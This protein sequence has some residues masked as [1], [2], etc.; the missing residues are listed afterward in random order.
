[1]YFCSLFKKK[2]P[3]VKRP[4][5]FLS[6]CCCMITFYSCSPPIS[7]DQMAQI[8]VEIYSLD[9]N[10]L[11]YPDLFTIGDTTMVYAALLKNN[12]Y[13]VKDFNRSIARHL[14]KPDKMKK[15]LTPYRDELMK[16]KNALQNELDEA[17]KELEVMEI[18]YPRKPIRDITYPLLSPNL[19][20][21]TMQSID[22]LKLLWASF[23]ERDTTHTHIFSMDVDP[24]VVADSLTTTHRILKDDK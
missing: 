2:L 21:V 19:D 11:N 14:Q 9:Q 4:T 15:A 3:T 8:M 18:I 24:D 6:I 17:S 16:K 7:R 22:S 20:T 12:G 10:I 1:M 5:L 13:S 23:W